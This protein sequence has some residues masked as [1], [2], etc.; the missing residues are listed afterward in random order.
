MAIEGATRLAKA[1][2]A[3]GHGTVDGATVTAQPLGAKRGVGSHPRSGIFQVVIATTATVTIEGRLD[4]SGTAP[5]VVIATF[6][7]SGAQAVEL[8]TFMRA[9][10]T[11]WTSGNVDAWLD[12]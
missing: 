8:F 11:A 6:T 2:V 9:N 4:N 5:W 1:Q 12:Q 7:V 10:V 3:T